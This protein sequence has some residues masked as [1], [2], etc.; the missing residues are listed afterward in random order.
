[1]HKDIW[2]NKVN[3]K[4]LVTQTGVMQLGPS[5]KRLKPSR[6]TRRSTVTFKLQKGCRELVK[7]DRKLIMKSP[8]CHRIAAPPTC[9]ICP[10]LECLDALGERNVQSIFIFFK[11]VGV[12]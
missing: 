11:Q 7:S 8:H 12:H 10:L 9:P 6:A 1:M 2:N 5:D 3:S 4:S